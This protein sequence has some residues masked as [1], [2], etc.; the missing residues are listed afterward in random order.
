MQAEPADQ[1]R[2]LD[3]QQA[4]TALTQLAHRRT[5]VS[6]EPQLA[7]VQKQANAIT[8]R[9]AQKSALAS[10]MERDIRRVEREVEQV[11]NRAE[12]D[13]QRQSSGAA[14]PKEL[15]NLTHELETLA[16]RQGELEDQQL[17]L[18]EKRESAEQGADGD[19]QLLAE[20]R[21]R[22]KELTASRDASL[23]SIDT[24][25]AFQQR[26]REAIAADLNA[27]LLQLYEKLR[28]SM[29]IAAALLRHRR[30]E[31][32][33]IEQSGGEL[34]ELRDAKPSDVMRCDNCRAILVRT[35][36]SGL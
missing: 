30:C 33:R 11:R 21:E 29:P 19:D 26:A 16:R 23:S 35:Q 27:E 7:D 6:E 34:A 32:C 9:Q 8:D 31:S 15:E 28:K 4:D 13:R 14:N 5:K 24:E 3:L 12:K 10:D 18:M 22:I 36:E 1:N 20:L 17:E 2:L 25:M